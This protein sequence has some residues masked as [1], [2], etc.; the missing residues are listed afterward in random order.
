MTTRWIDIPAADGK[1]FKAYLSLPPAGKGLGIVLIQEIF[2]VNK[3]IRAVADQ[4]ASD[5]Y[6]VL[7]PDLFWRMEPEVELGYA[8]PDMEKGLAFLQK[9]DFPAAVSDLA[10][11]VKTL[12]VMPECTGKVASLGFCMGGLLS[13]LC[14]ASA[15]VDAAVCYYGGGIHTQLDQAG[16]ITCPI[17]FHFAEKDGFIPMSAIEAVQKTFTGRPNATVHLYPNVDHGFNCW[18]RPSYHQPSA[19]LARGRSLQFLASVL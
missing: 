1:T 3:H 11:T 14:A 13:Y 16:K 10:S 19:A 7:T 12:R 9:L 15:G 5:G 4:W 2:G 8:G 17:L 18:E 6:T